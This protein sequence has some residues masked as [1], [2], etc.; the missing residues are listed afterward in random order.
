MPTASWYWLLLGGIPRSSS[1]PYSRA[2]PILTTINQQ[3]N[4]LISSHN[5]TS[6]HEI[7]QVDPA[8]HWN[9]AHIELPQQPLFSLCIYCARSCRMIGLLNLLWH[10]WSRVRSLFVGC[11]MPGGMYL[12]VHRCPEQGQ[13]IIF[14]KR[15]V[16]PNQRVDMNGWTR[17]SVP[18]IL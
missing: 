10:K 14:E 5:H 16:W 12:A 6:I 17:H 4:C 7:H 13:Q 1:K 18:N 2:F 15:Y 11:C 8:D 3:N 9:D